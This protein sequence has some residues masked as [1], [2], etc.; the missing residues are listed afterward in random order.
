MIA[1]WIL[2]GENTLKHWTEA[3]KNEKNWTLS[4]PQKIIS[5]GFTVFTKHNHKGI[6]LKYS[7][8]NTLSFIHWPT[9]PPIHLLF[10]KL[11]FYFYDI[12]VL[13]INQEHFI[14]EFH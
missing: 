3:K 7:L 4:E 12:V 2:Y 5:F 10:A 13:V 6:F 11:S 8:M 9:D 1:R 14:N